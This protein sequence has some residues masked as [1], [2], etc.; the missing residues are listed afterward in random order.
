MAPPGDT[1][2]APGSTPLR[3]LL[4]QAVLSTRVSRAWGWHFGDTR[5][6]RPFL[7]PNALPIP[8]DSGE[9]APPASCWQLSAP[10]D[11]GP[12]A[13]WL[14]SAGGGVHSS[15]VLGTVSPCPHLGLLQT[16]HSSLHLALGQ[17][18]VSAQPPRGWMSDPSRRLLPVASQCALSPQVCLWGWRSHRA[19]PPWSL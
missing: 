5:T 7:Q 6:A 17:G 8:Q 14:L 1:A 11:P 18:C 4:P 2:Q 9:G 19:Q 15:W 12:D 13:P 10:A 16:P 3:V